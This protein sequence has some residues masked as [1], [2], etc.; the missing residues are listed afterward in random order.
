MRTL[1]REKYMA[2]HRIARIGCLGTLSAYS[3]REDFD[4]FLKEVF[5]LRFPRIGDRKPWKKS[6]D[7][8][9]GKLRKDH[10]GKFYRL[11]S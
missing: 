4:W 8:L 6:F 11:I 2:S 3:S 7:S 9:R 1:T 5:D 10:S